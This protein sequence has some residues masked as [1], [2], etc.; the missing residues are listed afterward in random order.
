MKHHP[1]LQLLRSELGPPSPGSST[2]RGF[3][4]YPT[5]VH[6]VLSMGQAFPA[7]GQTQTGRAAWG[8]TQHRLSQNTLL[9][10]LCS[11]WQQHLKTQ[12]S[13]NSD[14]ADTTQ[15]TGRCGWMVLHPREMQ[16][17]FHPYCC[18]SLSFPSF[19]R[20][21]LLQGTKEKQNTGTGVSWLRQKTTL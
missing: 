2:A 12:L 8:V 13:L 4:V 10:P 14:T 20:V 7:R 3:Q 15:D 11:A 18:L 1:A 9:F 16:N 17:L 21:P 19:H 6:F 5:P